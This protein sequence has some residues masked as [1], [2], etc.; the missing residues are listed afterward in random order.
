VIMQSGR[1]RCEGSGRDGADRRIAAV[2]AD[3]GESLGGQGIQVGGE[4]FAF[5]R[6]VVLEV[7]EQFTVRERWHA[8]DARASTR[9]AV[10][11]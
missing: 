8:S 1:A 11:P 5:S 7:D 6:I 2:Y 4:P 3:G 10:C 9:A